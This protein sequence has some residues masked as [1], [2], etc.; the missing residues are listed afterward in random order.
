MFWDNKR[1][2]HTV[3]FSLGMSLVFILALNIAD[4]TIHT[5]LLVAGAFVMVGGQ[6]F[7]LLRNGVIRN[8]FHQAQ[9][10]FMKGDYQTAVRFL[11][12]YLR[13]QDTPDLKA[14]TLLGNTQRQLGNLDLSE[15]HLREAIDLEP[16]NAF[17]LYGLGR[18]LLAKGK[19]SE[20]ARFIQQALEQPTSRKSIRV[21][22]ALALH[23]AGAESSEIV[24]LCRQTARILRIET[25]R[26][27]M[28]NYL[29]YQHLD[30]NRLDERQVAKRIIHHTVSGLAFWQS[31][32]QRH[33]QTP[34]GERLKED[35]AAI[36]RLST[37]SKEE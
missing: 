28:A 18:T 15:R 32:A 16:Q 25:H 27:L 9:S 8:D 3:L 14:L 20:A 6:L 36:Q 30:E 7:L 12:D 2:R 23:Y 22:L 1:F 29:L 35:I 24:A 13:S 34:F 37:S 5:P 33:A 11:Q 4:E 19:F 10:A 31:E 21:E 17:P 26:V